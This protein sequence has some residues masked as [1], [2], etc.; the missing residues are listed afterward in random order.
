MKLLEVIPAYKDIIMKI[1]SAVIFFAA[2]ILATSVGQ[3]QSVADNWHQWRGPENNGVS[4]TADPP[5]EWSEEKNV[6]WKIEIGGHGTSSPIVW[7]NK[8]FLTTAVNTEKV[9]PSLP[10]PEDQP[11]RVFGIKH[12]NTSYQ[13]TVLCID[14]KTG[15]ELWRDV[16]KTLV[17]H[18]GHHRDASFASASPFCDD[19]RIYFWFGSGGLFAYSHDGKKLWERDLRKVKVGASLGEGSSPLVHDGKMVIVRDNAGQ[20]TIE[21][22]DASNGKLIWKKDRDERNAWATPAIAKYQGV[23]QVITCASNKVRSYNL[24]NGEI[25]WEA[26][27]LTSNCIPCPIVH[28]EVVYCMSGYKGYS[29]LA[30]P[31][32]GKGDVTDSVLWK[33]MRGTPYIPSPLLYDGLLYFTQS[34]QNLMTCVDIK[35]GSQVIEK[36]RLP[37]LGGIYSSPVGA[38]GRIYM[39][40]R[41]GTV[42][43]LKRGDKTKVLATNQLDDDFHASPALAGKKLF[44]RGMRFLYCLE[45][46]R[47]P[48]KQKIVSK[49]PAKKKPP[50]ASSKKSTPGFAKDKHP[51]VVTLLVDDLGYRDIGCYGGPVKTPVLDKLAAGGVRF[52]DFHSGAP[53]CSPS[54]ATF[55]TGRHHYRAGVYSVITERLH[56]MHLLKSETTI[57]EVLKENGYATAHF[58]KWHLGMPVQNRKNPTPGDHGFDYWFGLVNGPGPS[59]KN[60]TQF[61]RNGK[62]VGQIKG[63]SSQIVVDEAITWLNEKREADEPFFLNL[64]FNE[65]H[66]PIAA[67]D[68]IVSHYGPLDDQ[69]AIYSGTIDNT[70]R[71]IGRLVA[72]L[73][74]LD[75]LD[76]TIIVYSSDNGSY[77]QERSGELRGQKGSKFEG[78]HRV[79]GIFYWKGGILG[80]RVED[81]PAGVVDLLPTLCGLIGIEKPEKVHLDGSDLTTMLTGSGKFNRHQPLFWMTG[82]NMVLRMGDH[83]LFAYGTAK[84]PIDFKAAN[85]LTEQIKQVLGDDLEKVLDGRDIKDLRN[86]LFNHGKLANPE[87]NR[88]K[89]QLRDLYYFNEDWIPELKNSEIGRVQLY[90]LS[91]DLGQQ[92]NIAK[93]RP[94]LVT[95]LKK[96]AAAIYR[97][98]MADAPEWSS[99]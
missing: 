23:T 6:A 12:P 90:D 64:W 54:R 68:E 65:P 87:A 38:A 9:D 24:I 85:R 55:L 13:M 96:Q 4:R 58:G 93:K 99:K 47:A 39:T 77:R 67:P 95:Q 46:E 3:A 20:S 27:G 16:A 84:S 37:G 83:T 81:E 29:L 66:A 70:D 89:N 51:N 42:L 73:E 59:H 71:A 25:I 69:A 78:G 79:P 98:V 60:P 97:S 86:R 36:D 8:V 11:E 21:V 92:N 62:R 88:L 17:P 22:L 14:K 35:D 15:N 7:G 18:E 43:V 34:N 41:K 44:L 30:I 52:T 72:R 61:L 33:V 26:K 48:A 10:K 82:A 91:R 19:K 50:N 53:S 63:Y 40:D 75:E 74:K 28:E 94:K 5:V 45:E 80:G 32:T 49:Q 1:C 76:N 31:I 2:S 56:K 57:A